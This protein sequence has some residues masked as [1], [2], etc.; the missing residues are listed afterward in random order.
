MG[1]VK[2]D[3]EIHELA[4]DQLYSSER[5]YIELLQLKKELEDEATHNTRTVRR[6]HQEKLQPRHNLSTEVD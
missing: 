4:N 1:F 6:A 2:R 3:W 5:E